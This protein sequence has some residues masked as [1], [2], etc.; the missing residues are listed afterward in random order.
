MAGDGIH[1]PC[2]KFDGHGHGGGITVFNCHC[3]SP[4]GVSRIP[5]RF[6]PSRGPPL[7]VLSVA[8]VD[9]DDVKVEVDQLPNDE[10]LHL[11][12]GTEDDTCRVMLLDAEP[13]SKF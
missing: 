5:G 13:T 11:A 2:W 8:I 9:D 10:T 6:G 7:R 4:V 12:V 1:Q 3:Q